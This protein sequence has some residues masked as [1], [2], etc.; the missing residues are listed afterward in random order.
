MP[1]PIMLAVATALAVR[2]AEA[3]V[4][5]GPAALASLVRLVRRRFAVNDE[6]L[7]TLEVA[8]AQP[9]DPASVRALAG[10][11]DRFAAQD[12]EFDTELRTLWAQVGD[13]VHEHGPVVNHNSGTITGSLLQG[14]DFTLN[15]H[16]N[17]GGSTEPR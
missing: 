1:D 12:R 16:L 3:A 8:Q 6:A 5:S 4:A 10:T 7:K 9:D 15:G 13:T 17:F 2:T 14:R 11:L